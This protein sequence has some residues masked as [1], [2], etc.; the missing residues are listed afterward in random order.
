VT[1]QSQLDLT[2]SEIKGTIGRAFGALQGEGMTAVISSTA[3]LDHITIAAEIDLLG[4]HQ[5]IQAMTTL[6]QARLADS[7]ADA[8]NAIAVALVRIERAIELDQVE[9]EHWALE[10]PISITEAKDAGLS[11]VAVTERALTGGQP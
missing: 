2:T 9:Q 11:I 3:A 8:K 4:D 5:L 1:T 6:Q 10:A 7:L